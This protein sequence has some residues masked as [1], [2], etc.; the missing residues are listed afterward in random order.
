MEDLP[1]LTER[2]KAFHVAVEVMQRRQADPEADPAALEDAIVNV[3]AT[4][5]AVYTQ[6]GEMSSLPTAGV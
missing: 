5:A 1:E 2:V 6:L 3:R 4:L